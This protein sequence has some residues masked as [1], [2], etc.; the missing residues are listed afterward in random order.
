M[1]NDYNF[2]YKGIVSWSVG[3]LLDILYLCFLSLAYRY[4]MAENEVGM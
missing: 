1:F 2:H 4:T 3:D